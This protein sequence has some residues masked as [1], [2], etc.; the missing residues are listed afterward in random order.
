MILITI[1]LDFFLLYA[2]GLWY[3][4]TIM[5]IEPI[6]ATFDIIRVQ[7]M[8]SG[9]VR[10][11]FEAD[12]TRTDLLQKLADVKRGGGLLETVMLP[13]LPQKEKEKS[14]SDTMIDDID[15]GR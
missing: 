14:W 6:K 7:T 2:Y 3:N 8:A 9:A 12:E 4:D 11:V 5:A 15:I 1:I 10:I 13:V